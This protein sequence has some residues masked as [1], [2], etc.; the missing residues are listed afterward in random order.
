MP[1]YTV[2]LGLFVCFCFHF[3]CLGKPKK[4]F[5]L[6][7]IKLL[8]VGIPCL[9]PDFSRKAFSFS[10]WNTILAVGLSWM[11]FM[12]LRYVSS[13]SNLVRVFIMYRGWI[14]SNAFSASIEMIVWF[15]TSFVSVV[16]EVD[17]LICIY[18]TILVNLGWI[19]L[20][21]GIWTFYVLLDSV[22]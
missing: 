9:V 17:W 22:G 19:P 14:L 10:L 6:C 5:V 8:R 21:L 15:L 7:W 20:G 13:V 18:W 1:T 2:C 12:M 16:Y 3:Y 4:I 11:V